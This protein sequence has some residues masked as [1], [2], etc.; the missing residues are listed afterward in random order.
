MKPTILISSDNAE[1]LDFLN[2]LLEAEGFN[3]RTTN[4]PEQAF[5]IAAVE[6]PDITL[7]D[8]LSGP[9]PALNFQAKLMRS[10]LTLINDQTKAR[11]GGELADAT[12]TV[13]A[14]TDMSSDDAQT[15]LRDAG[16]DECI[17]GPP[18]ATELV[19]RLRGLLKKSTNTGPTRL[20]YAD[21]EM[22]LSVSRVLRDGQPVE[23]GAT[24]FRLLHRLLEQPEK[25]FSRDELVDRA[26]ANKVDPGSRTVDV[27]IGR[28][29]QAL[30]AGS[31]PDMIRTVRSFGYALSGGADDD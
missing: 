14:L 21:V 7:I 17:V 29:R 24:E 13:V 10:R 6:A 31:K 26:W 16:V 4:G 12:L 19:R 25:V 30:N 22:D 20:A 8:C 27:H 28:L 3:T 2:Y 5:R 11:G 23:L 9:G 1:F 15:R 18:P